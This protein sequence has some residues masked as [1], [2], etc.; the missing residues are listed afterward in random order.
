MAAVGFVAIHYP[1]AEHHDEFVARPASRGGIAVDA[2][3]PG[4]RLLACYRQHCCGVHRA[5]GV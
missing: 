1:R 3:V 5:M 2:R 4:R